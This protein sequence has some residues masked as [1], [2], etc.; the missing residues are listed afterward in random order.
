MLLA[1]STRIQGFILH[2]LPLTFLIAVLF[3]TN[4]WIREIALRLGILIDWLI[5]IIALGAGIVLIAEG[6]KQKGRAES[7]NSGVAGMALMSFIGFIIILTGVLQ[8][9]GYYDLT[10]GTGDAQVFFSIMWILGVIVFGVLTIHSVMLSSKVEI[11]RPHK[12]N[13]TD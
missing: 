6:F 3:W 12:I 4:A 7:I 9:T 2:F 13:T 10:T 8:V 11:L 5:F 1:K